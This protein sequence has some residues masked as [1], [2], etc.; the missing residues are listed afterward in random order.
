M[1]E[2]IVIEISRRVARDGRLYVEVG[3]SAYSLVPAFLIRLREGEEEG[4]GLCCF[5]EEAVGEDVYEF[6]VSLLSIKEPQACT[7]YSWTMAAFQERSMAEEKQLG[8]FRVIDIQPQVI[9]Y[10]ARPY[11]LHAS[12][13]DQ[14]PRIKVQQRI[15]WH[16]Q[17]PNREARSLAFHES[18]Q[19]LAVLPFCCLCE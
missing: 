2:V 19:R 7:C 6:S 17:T 14:H 10:V 16:L 15:P 12:N 5:E 9:H 13:A 4:K 11:E 1:P 8:C 3:F 18:A